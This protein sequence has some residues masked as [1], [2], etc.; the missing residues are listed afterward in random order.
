MLIKSLKS[1][2]SPKSTIKT[3]T[4]KECNV[5]GKKG[6]LSLRYIGPFEVL[7]KIGLVAYWLDLSPSMFG[8]HPILHDSMI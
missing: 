6:K 1:L 7:K 3:L 2:K 8:V 4:L 5:I